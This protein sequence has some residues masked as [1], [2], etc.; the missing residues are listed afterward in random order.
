MVIRDGR[1]PGKGAFRQPQNLPTNGGKIPIRRMESQADAGRGFQPVGQQEIPDQTASAPPRSPDAVAE[2]LRGV[3]K[4]A[5]EVPDAAHRGCVGKQPRVI[6][7]ER[8]ACALAHEPG[9]SDKSP[10]GLTHGFHHFSSSALEQFR[11]LALLQIKKLALARRVLAGDH[12]PPPSVLHCGEPPMEIA[13]QDQF[14]PLLPAVAQPPTK[15]G[16]GKSRIRA[17]PVRNDQQR[18]PLHAHPGQIRQHLLRAPPASRTHVVD[19][20]DQSGCSRGAQSLHLRF[21]LFQ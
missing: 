14:V 12:A 11:R 13:V 5:L 18:N 3:K 1:T 21:S 10:H 19:G 4:A 2:A 15:P 6:L 16:V 17:V 8:P 7:A 20:H 9:W